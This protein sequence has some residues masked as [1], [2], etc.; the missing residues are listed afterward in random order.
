MA[1][2]LIYKKQIKNI[3]ITNEEYKNAFI[4]ASNARIALILEDQ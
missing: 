2:G 1:N 3:M 4:R